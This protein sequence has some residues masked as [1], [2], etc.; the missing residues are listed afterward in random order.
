MLTLKPLDESFPIHHQLGV[1]V[2]PVVFVNLFTVAAL[3]VAALLKAW[4][5]DANWMK[6]QP[7]YISTQL[8]RAVGEGYVFMNYALWES[9][10][11]SKNQNCARSL[12]PARMQ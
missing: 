11:P 7:S 6:K 2:S 12:G 1:E 5:A 9:V 4:E 8:H 3:D 10:V